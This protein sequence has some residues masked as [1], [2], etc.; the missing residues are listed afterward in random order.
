[1]RSLFRTAL[2]FGLLLGSVAVI[3]DPAMA[4]DQK[5]SPRP[6][7][8]DP[9]FA[10]ALLEETRG[11]FDEAKR[12]YTAILQSEPNNAECC[13]KLGT[14]YAKLNR[15]AEAEV[16]YRQ[17]SALNPDN[18]QLLADRGFSALKRKDYFRAEEWLEKSVKLD[19]GKDV[20][21]NNKTT[22]RNLAIARGW[23]NK[24]ELCLETFR[25]ITDE[26]EA[27]RSLAAIQSA[28]GDTVM[29]Q[30]NLE[31][32]KGIGQ[33]AAPIPDLLPPA[34]EGSIASSIPTLPPL[35][36]TITA[37]NVAKVEPDSVTTSVPLLMQEP[38]PL[39]VEIAKLSTA[40]SRETVAAVPSSGNEPAPR[41]HRGE[42]LSRSGKSLSNRVLKASPAPLMPVIESNV[43]LVATCGRPSPSLASAP[44]SVTDSS[45]D[46]SHYHE[47]SISADPVTTEPEELDLQ[48]KL[49]FELPVKASATKSTESDA[50]R[51]IETEPQR[52]A[53][54]DR[55][56]STPSAPSS[57]GV[58]DPGSGQNSV[59][60]SAD[61]TLDDVCLVTLRDKRELKKGLPEHVY[62]FHGQKY[63]CSSAAALQKLRAEPGHYVPAAGGLDVVSFKN[64]RDFSQGSLKFSTWYENR[65]FL[66]LSQE[67]CDEFKTDPLK[68]A[69]RE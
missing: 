57:G 27:L 30:R 62:E 61:M 2:S 47:K 14:V 4:A 17:A 42:I 60:A 28:R 65:L 9:R 41:S 68:Y 23:L 34:P 56:H 32:A 20:A 58:K 63:R 19:A 24:D 15:H 22:L 10:A 31:L 16:Y 48:S 51:L 8:R 52:P 33:A 7:R 29:A 46:L 69:P 53:L 38:S 35:E 13:H 37:V 50:P 64:N 21:A 6:V 3:H 49:V 66:F 18:A 26:R 39:P 25:R 67:N 12:L 11:H 59:S 5:G 55:T 40:Q 36:T 43:D 54:S 45:V 44:P 1:M